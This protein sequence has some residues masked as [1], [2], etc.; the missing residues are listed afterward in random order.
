MAASVAAGTVALM[1][2]ANPSLT[3]NAVKAI[4]QYTAQEYK[5]YDP[6]T[7]GAGFINA[8]GA[9]DLAVWLAASTTSPA[10]SSPDW[11]GHIIWGNNLVGG[12]D[13]AAGATAWSLD[14][15][16]GAAVTP[17][18]APISWGLNKK[19]VWQLSDIA[20]SKI[21]TMGMCQG[22]CQEPGRT[23][24]VSS[25]S[26]GESD[27]VVWGT[28]DGEADTVV[29]GTSGCSDPSCEPVIWKKQ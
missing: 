3:P 13:L 9:V 15:T 21:V 8:K 7:Q 11:S 23:S 14:V 17:T 22:D 20:P 29:W 10:P 28:S 4:L 25:A 6:L 26:E 2:Q 24:Q 5:G 12:G 18:G 19:R 1:I 16:W 27:T